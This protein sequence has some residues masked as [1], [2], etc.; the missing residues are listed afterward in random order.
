MA[1]CPRPVLT[2]YGPTGTYVDH[3]HITYFRIG[4]NWPNYTFCLGQTG[5]DFYISTQSS[6]PVNSTGTTTC[7]CNDP[8]VPDSAG[9]SCVPAPAV[10]CPIPSL[11]PLTDQVAIDFDNNVGS[12]WR[13][14]GLI[15]AYQEHVRCVEREI[16]AR[17]GTPVGTSAYRPKQYQQHL[18]E[19]VQKDVQLKPSLMA[20]H[21]ECQALRDE[22]HA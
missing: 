12:R 3:F 2:D 5:D 16:R 20:A 21:P 4:W 8:Y 6:C 13:P 17:G 18:F 11:T 14:E 10:S 1:Q 22:I 15:P 9:T 7:T 19:I